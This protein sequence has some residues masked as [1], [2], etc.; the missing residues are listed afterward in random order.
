[1]HVQFKKY[2]KIQDTVDLRYVVGKAHPTRLLTKMAEDCDIQSELAAI[3]AEFV[4]AQMDGLI[5][6]WICRVRNAHPTNWTLSSRLFHPKYESKIT[7]R[8]TLK[9][10]YPA[11]FL[12]S[13]MQHNQELD[14]KFA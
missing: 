12:I 7:L 2:T 13:H 1:V 8:L 6:Q 9:F 11:A 14:P 4:I 3:N 5:I 10:L